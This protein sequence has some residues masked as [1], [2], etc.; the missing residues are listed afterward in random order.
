M[1][2]CN[3]LN[4]CFTLHELNHA[5]WAWLSGGTMEVGTPEHVPK[6]RDAPLVRPARRP[7]SAARP[8]QVGRRLPDW[9]SAVFERGA[10]RPGDVGQHHAPT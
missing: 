1:G 6:W 8:D 10:T 5:R 3:A 4:A 9:T 7:F 2:F